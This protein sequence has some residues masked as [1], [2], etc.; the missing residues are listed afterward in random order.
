M[1]WNDYHTLD[2][3]YTWLDEISKRYPDIVTPF[4]IGYSYEGRLIK[5]IKISYKPGNK[6]VF[7]ESNIHAR[8]WITSATITY[9][10][11]ELLVPRN[12]GVR[13]IAELVDFIII[14][15]LNVDG[16]VHSHE[17]VS[18]DLNFYKDFYVKCI[19]SWII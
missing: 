16:F 18:V 2:E 10:I 9:I 4:T 17:H 1:D 8:E 12:P 3:I 7:I 15:V 13:K 5:G 19:T 14:P 6:A 11:D